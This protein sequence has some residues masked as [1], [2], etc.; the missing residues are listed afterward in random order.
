[1]QFKKNYATMALMAL[2]DWKTPSKA[3]EPGGTGSTNLLLW[4][5]VLVIEDCFV[6]ESARLV[7]EVAGELRD[8]T[9]AA[10][11]ALAG[12]RANDELNRN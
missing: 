4:P 2:P 12:M 11:W 1:M 10:L 7:V 8:E 6:P 9:C 3:T 5:L